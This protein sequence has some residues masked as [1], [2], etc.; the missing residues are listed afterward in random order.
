MED[1]VTGTC[2]ICLMLYSFQNALINIRFVWVLIL[3][4]TYILF[5]YFL[6]RLMSK[7]LGV[8]EFQKFTW[9]VNNITVLATSINVNS[10]RV[11]MGILIE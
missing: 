6:G 11:Y 1:K 5:T 9:V 7:E 4:K 10:R 2:H 3:Y 8:E